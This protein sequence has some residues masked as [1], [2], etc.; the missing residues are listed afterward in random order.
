MAM[1]LTA[2]AQGTWQEALGRQLPLLGQHNWVIIAD[3]AFPLLT[4]PGVETIYAPG[5]QMHVVA[6][7][8]GALAGTKH[9]APVIY[10]EAELKLV[11]EKRAAGI[12]NYRA[13]LE[14]TLAG[15]NVASLPHNELAAKLEEAARTFKVL[16]IK[17]SL[18]LPYSSVYVRLD[19]AY[20]N[21]EAEAELRK[22]AG[23]A[24]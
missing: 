18:T 7:V 16:V 20:W 14:R 10:T 4:N 3:A 5:D 19:S 11:T 22:A 13:T 6:G 12:D 21:A 1:S 8:L 2:L 24:K 15:N 17:T 23:E 9:L